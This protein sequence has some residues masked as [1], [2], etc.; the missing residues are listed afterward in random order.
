MGGG[1]G[2]EVGGRVREDLAIGREAAVL[3]ISNV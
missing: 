1:G 3:E 2:R